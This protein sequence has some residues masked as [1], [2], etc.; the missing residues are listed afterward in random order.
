MAVGAPQ[1]SD[2]EW[3]VMKVIWQRGSA[4]AAEVVDD[5]APATAWHPRTV[6][7]M[8]NRLVRKG[9]LDFKPEGKRYIYRARVSRQACVRRATRSFLR[10]V[11][12][13]AAA[14]AVAHFL[15]DARLSPGEIEQLKRI[16]D[17]G[18]GGAR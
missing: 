9:A 16:L 2:A 4:T 17:E 11:F 14:P 1:I 18:R 8:L 10:R 3:E 15:E 6:K 5:L 13:G 7:T 12:D